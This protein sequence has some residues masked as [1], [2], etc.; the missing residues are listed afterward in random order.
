MIAGLTLSILILLVP[1]VL[2]VQLLWSPNDSLR[3]CLLLKIILGTGLGFGTSSILLFV[4]LRVFGSISGS[5]LVAEASLALCCSVALVLIWRKTRAPLTGV[6]QVAPTVHTRLTYLTGGALFIS[7]VCILITASVM[8]AREPHGQGDATAIWNLI[9]RFIFR[10]GSGWAETLTYKLAWTHS[11][12]PLLLPLSV[13][14]MWAF[15]GETQLVPALIGLMFMSGTLGLLVTSVS[16]LRTRTQGYLAGLVLLEPFLFFR[17]GTYEYADTPLGFFLLAALVIFCLNDKM[18]GSYRLLILAGMMAGFAA[19]TKNEGLLVLCSL[20][21]ARFVG[22]VA[23]QNLRT[24]IRQMLYFAIG[25]VPV[26]LVVV[27]FKLTIAPANDLAA[28]QGLRVTAYRLLD[29]SRY[30]VILKA[31]LNQ[32][33]GFRRWY[34]HPTYLLTIYAWL[35]GVKTERSER[36]TLLTLTATLGLIMVGYFFVYVTTPRDLEWHLT[37]SLDRLLIQLWPSIVLL[38][39][40]LVNSPENALAP[41]RRS[42][43]AT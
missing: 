26:I 25:A 17:V 9:A 43:R 12:Y 37:F 42:A 18:A 33:T 23:S 10:G 5:Y 39:F 38:Y 27:Y 24:Y 21:T 30:V 15:A 7:V 16:H 32:L 14:R 11:D 1:G 36:T 6:L 20:V 4:W 29:F 22:V 41:V 34:L 35:L 28:G 19:W 3:T 40:F 13:A 8:S 31:L 2:L